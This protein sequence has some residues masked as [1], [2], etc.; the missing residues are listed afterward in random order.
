[1]SRQLIE[2]LENIKKV[3]GELK[4]VDK[5]GKMG[6]EDFRVRAS[7]DITVL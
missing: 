5:T 6:V 4:E 7:T 1:M 2:D 3:Q